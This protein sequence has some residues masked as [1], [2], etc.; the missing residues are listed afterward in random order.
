M[1]AMKKSSPRRESEHEQTMR[2]LR[3]IEKEVHHILAIVYKGPVTDLPPELV[4][5][6]D[7]AAAK[8]KDL[9]AALNTQ[10]PQPK[11]KEQTT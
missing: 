1:R 3:K 6:G 7:D 9:Q 5:A 2:L 8:S 4:K 10:A 11:Q